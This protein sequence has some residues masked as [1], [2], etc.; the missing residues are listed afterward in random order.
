MSAALASKDCDIEASV[1]ELVE[2]G[3]AEVTRG[4]RER[5]VSVL[6]KGGARAQGMR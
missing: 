3:W 5:L 1:E 2:N 6:V 4:L